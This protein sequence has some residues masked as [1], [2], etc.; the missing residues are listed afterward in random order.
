MNKMMYDQEMLSALKNA[1]NFMLCAHINPDGDAVG[2]MLAL[3]RLLR[4]MGKKAA[5]V[6]PNGVPA[7]FAWLPDADRILS[8]EQAQHCRFDAAFSVDVPEPHRMGNVYALY[9][10][11]AVTFAVD[12]HPGKADFARFHLVDDGASASAELIVALYE[13][14]DVPLDQA[15]ALQLYAGISTD[16]G[17]FVFSS[18]RPYTFYCMQKLME[19]GLDLSEAARRLFLI[20]T[21]PQTAALGRALQSMR[22]FADGRA[23]CMHL[24]AQDKAEC[25]TRDDDLHGMVNYGLNLEGVAMTFMADE[26]ESG[27]KISLRALPGGDVASIA[28]RFGGGGHVLAAGCEMKGSYQEIETRLMAAVEEALKA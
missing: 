17:N 12:H 1:D 4:G 8:W 5:M 26:C 16:T 24:S 2:S 18:V 22:Y 28:R 19:A 25:H 15:A 9:E 3:G 10:Q 27:W 21:R 20:K 14:L 23:T 11:A 7:R 13:A 6:C